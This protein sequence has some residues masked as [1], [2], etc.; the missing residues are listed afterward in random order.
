MGMS[1]PLMLSRS[2]ERQQ[3]YLSRLLGYALLVL[4]SYG[5][6]VGIL[7]RHDVA[8]RGKAASSTAATSNTPSNSSKK[9]P[10]ERECLVCQF[11]RGLSSAAF[12]SPLAVFASTDVQLA[13]SSEQVLQ[14]S[15]ATGTAQGRAPPVNL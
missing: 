7:H 6:T 3:A 2:H 5:S 14:I 1:S 4:I 11:H 15:T 8:S 9:I 12:F 10:T 13:P